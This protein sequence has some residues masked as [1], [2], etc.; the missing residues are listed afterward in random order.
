MF[1]CFNLKI[2]SWINSKIQ[3]NITFFKTNDQSTNYDWIVQRKVW[4]LSLNKDTYTCVV[5]LFVQWEIVTVN[6]CKY[7][8]S[9]S[10]LSDF[11][12][13]VNKVCF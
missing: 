9:Y 11:K 8:F 13:F 2:S 6:V 1:Y 4:Y 5:K 3:C 12:N 7:L 10:F